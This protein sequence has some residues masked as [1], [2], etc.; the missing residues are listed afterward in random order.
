MWGFVRTDVSPQA[1]RAPVAE[2]APECRI[3]VY[4]AAKKVAVRFGNCA[5]LHTPCTCEQANIGMTLRSAVAFGV[6]EVVVVGKR[7]SV[8][9]CVAACV[10][11]AGSRVTTSACR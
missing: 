9:L 11:A 7:R 4:N 6:R 2:P 8:R 5:F 3:L 10:C 1:A